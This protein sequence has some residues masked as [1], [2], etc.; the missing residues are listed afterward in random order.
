[1]DH[2]FTRLTPGADG[3][4]HAVLH[5]ADGAG[6]V[7]QWRADDL[8]RVQVHTADRPEPTSDS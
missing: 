4:V 2:A 8:P 1:M 3:L 5:G 7:L 6:V